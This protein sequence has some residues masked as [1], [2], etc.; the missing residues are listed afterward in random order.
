[1]AGLSDLLKTA[2]LAHVRAYLQERVVPPAV[3][4]VNDSFAPR[5]LVKL[6]RAIEPLPTAQRELSSYRTRIGTMLEYA[7]STAID[8]VLMDQEPEFQLCFVAYHDYPDFVLRDSSYGVALRIEMKS[9][10]SESDE[11][12]ARFD[13]ATSRIDPVKD[14]VLFVAW[15]WAK[16]ASRRVEVEYP[17]IFAS[18]IVEAGELA[19][20]RDNRLNERGGIIRGEQVLVPSTKNPGQ[21]V[22]DPGNY[23]K[24]WRIVPPERWNAAD[25]SEPA[26]IFVDFLRRLDDKAPH[27][28]M[29]RA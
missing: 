25:L 19:K 10:E 9:V 2:D 3:D 22:A 23:G 11:Q 21:L 18:A 20:E 4:R 7:L 28:R 13:A 26:R 12:A 8:R 17:R 24:L 15:E 29:H 1:M 5:R 27:R 16:V 6:A 14:L